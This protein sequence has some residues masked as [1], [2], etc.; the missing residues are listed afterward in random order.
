V[1]PIRNPHPTPLGIS[2]FSPR[3]VRR[4]TRIDRPAAVTGR[5]FEGHRPQA[6][7]S[8]RDLDLPAGELLV[9]KDNHLEPDEEARARN[10]GARLGSSLDETIGRGALSR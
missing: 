6:P 2:A 1:G 5:A 3:V 7:P 10:R 8:G 4:E 9:T